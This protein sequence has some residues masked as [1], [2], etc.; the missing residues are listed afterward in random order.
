MVTH[1]VSTASAINVMKNV[2]LRQQATVT[3]DLDKFDVEKLNAELGHNFSTLTTSILVCL[4][5]WP[6]LPEHFHR[7]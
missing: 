1:T 6:D 5:R 3:D 4:L 7:S 2:N